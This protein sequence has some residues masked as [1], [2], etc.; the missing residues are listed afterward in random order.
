MARAD[1]SVSDVLAWARTRPADELYDF[2]DADNCAIAQ[3]GRATDRP[4][5][6]GVSSNIF[7]PELRRA[8]HPGTAERGCSIGFY[9]FGGLVTRLEALLPAA[10]SDTWTKAESYLPIEVE[11]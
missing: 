3:F 10:V 5:L 4:H 9:R 7:T 6:V 1:F 8:L 2:G 11:A